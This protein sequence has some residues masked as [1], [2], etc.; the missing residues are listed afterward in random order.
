MGSLVPIG[1]T[2][3]IAMIFKRMTDHA[4]NF[5]T[6][7]ID[8]RKVTD[9][10]LDSIRKKILAM[11]S[12][13]GGATELLKGY[14]QVISAGVTET[15]ASQDMLTTSAKASKASHTPL[16][17]VIK[18]LTKMM[19]G[20]EGEISR[21]IDASDLLFA[22]EKEGQT[23]FQELIPIIGGLSKMSRDLNID[24][25]ELGGSLALITQTA[26]NTARA[27]TQYRGLLV[28]LM[29][30]TTELKAALDEMG[31]SNAE[32]ALK[33]MGL[34][35]FLRR[36]EER[37]GGASDKMAELVSS[38][39]AI[40]GFSALSAQNF[41]ILAD[42]IEATGRASGGTERAFGALG[43]SARDASKI[44]KAEFEAMAIAS[45]VS[46]LTVKTAAL[47][48]ASFT[49][50]GF[51]GFGK[52]LGEFAAWM[53][54]FDMSV[55]KVPRTLEN[56]TSEIKTLE[57][58]VLNLSAAGGYDADV[59]KLLAMLREARLLRQE[60]SGEAAKKGTG[61]T[62]TAAADAAKKSAKEMATGIKIAFEI[63]ETESETALINMAEKALLSFE[64]IKGVGTATPWDIAQAYTAAETQISAAL[65]RLKGKQEE[66]AE[67][68]D[69]WYKKLFA[70]AEGEMPISE[71]YA[72]IYKGPSK[73]A[74]AVAEKTGIIEDMLKR[75]DE[76]KAA[77]SVEVKG[78]ETAISRLKKLGDALDGIGKKGVTI[79][80]KGEGSRVLPISEKIEEIKTMFGSL[81]NT[82]PQVTA[83]FSSVTAGLQDFSSRMEAFSRFSQLP[84]VQGYMSRQAAHGS[85][86][87]SEDLK[88][89]FE[90]TTGRSIS[91]GE[92][93]INGSSN[94]AEMARILRAELL[95]LE[96]YI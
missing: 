90:Q 28:S 49:F 10:S 84:M 66:T 64:I 47:R 65:D 78:V 14:Y 50:K 56:I 21:V 71:L 35:E 46:L 94:P 42:K 40:V 52:G 54:G 80:I 25:R 48:A 24:S 57:D 37:T 23:N 89:L 31:F 30:P 95:K 18:G 82:R 91:V 87:L 22:I 32:T 38:Q 29:K 92:I 13:L 34:I 79:P 83:D 19:A 41:G 44:A 53:A 9:E 93:N 75:L 96:S 12:E 59:Q 5:Q 27:A 86:T 72:D 20:Y 43:E 81:E 11:P 15:A 17:E 68:S 8:M 63:L 51:T 85:M 61:D 33:S 16:S 3:G 26:G 2:A 67:A 70:A 77:P 60:L 88:R 73:A 1:V 74:D 4:E 6:A 36:L 55:E 69:D 45:E 76:L 7:L 58:A 39:E 62:G